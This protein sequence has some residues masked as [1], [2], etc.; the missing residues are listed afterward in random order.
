MPAEPVPA[1]KV[2]LYNLLLP[3]ASEI[4]R[5]RV[6]SCYVTTLKLSAFF[7]AESF[8]IEDRIAGR[9]PFSL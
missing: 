5:R 7:C 2:L 3:C 8:F 1:V 4:D 6:K 9:L